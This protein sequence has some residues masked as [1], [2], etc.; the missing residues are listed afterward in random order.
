MFLDLGHFSDSGLEITGY[1]YLALVELV[2]MIYP[3]IGGRGGGQELY[4]DYSGVSR[5]DTARRMLNVGILTKTLV[6]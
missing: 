1:F 2:V 6:S 3:R 4:S 5:R